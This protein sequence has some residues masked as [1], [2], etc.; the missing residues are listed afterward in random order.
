MTVRMSTTME[1]PNASE[2]GLTVFGTDVPLLLIAIMTFV[3][4]GSSGT[5]AMA[6]KF[7]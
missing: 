3:L 2:A 4:M 7:G 1:W 6:V 5:M